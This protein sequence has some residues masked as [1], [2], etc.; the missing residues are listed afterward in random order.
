MLRLNWYLGVLL[1]ALVVYVVGAAVTTAM[2]DGTGAEH[3]VDLA[4]A[5]FSLPLFASATVVWLGGTYREEIAALLEARTRSSKSVS[6]AAAAEADVLNW[7]ALQTPPGVSEV[8][9]LQWLQRRG[10]A[11]RIRADLLA[12][13]WIESTASGQF[14]VSNSGRDILRQW[15]AREP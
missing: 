15:L 13:G 2:S 5:I 9:L 10:R 3:L 11:T 14:A 4:E 6:A 1:T 12:R 8:E 7:I